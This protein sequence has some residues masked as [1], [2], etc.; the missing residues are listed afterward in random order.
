MPWDAHDH[1]SVTPPAPREDLALLWF[2][3][4]VQEGEILG[5]RQPGR[6]VPSG[7]RVTGPEALAEEDRESHG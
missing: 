6:E 1:N 2:T 4:L 3:C 5:E 7:D